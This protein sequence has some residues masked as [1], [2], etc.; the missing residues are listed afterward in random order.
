MK[1]NFIIFAH[2]LTGGTRVIM[3]MINAL[4]KRGHEIVLI[5]KGCPA[6]LDWIELHAKVLYFNR[7]L[8]EK[9][10][11]FLYRKIFGFQ[12]WPE[13][14]TRKILHIMPKADINIAAISY[15][16][17]AVHRAEQGVPLHYSMHYE[18]LVA[19]D[20]NKKKIIE[21]AYFLPIYKIANSTWLAEQIKKHTGQDVAGLVFPALDHGIFYQREKKRP[22]SRDQK[23]KIV[24]LAKYKLWKGTFDVLKAIQIVRD[25]GYNVDFSMFGN[26][27]PRTLPDEVK[28]IEFNFVGSKKDNALAEF[29]NNADIL[30]SASFFESFPLPQLEAMACG[31]PV[32]TTK[33]G[34]EDYAIDGENSFV[35]EPRKPDEMAKAIIR[36]IET[37]ELYAKFIENGIRTAE[38]FTWEHAAEQM[39]KILLNISRIPD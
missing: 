14:E 2:T 5:T 30:I 35:V 36:L 17:F 39:E 20:E 33:Y 6:D 15:S 12:P 13:E 29:Y 28:H 22:K 26:F 7:T 38:Q 18:P 34:T 24:S 3:E 4:A 10:I 32:V 21:A 9:M 27:D 31:T 25:S 37:P 11:G 8:L 23:I 19:E 1:I 16:G